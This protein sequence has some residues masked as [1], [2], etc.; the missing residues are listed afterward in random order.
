[1]SEISKNSMSNN[2]TNRE[3]EYK[4]YE[5]EYRDQ[6]WLDPAE[7]APECYIDEEAYYCTD[8]LSRQLSSEKWCKPKSY[9]TDDD[10]YQD[11][12]NRFP[13]WNDFLIPISEENKQKTKDS[14]IS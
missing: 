9:D 6:K 8:D 4:Y 3:K 13:E 7:R 1:M 11:F 14:Q 10:R 12:E 2:A 5:R